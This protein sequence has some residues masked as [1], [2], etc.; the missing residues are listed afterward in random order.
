MRGITHR[1]PITLLNASADVR[2]GVRQQATKT[3]CPP[4]E[5]YSIDAP[6]LNTESRL[7]SRQSSA[8]TKA[9]H[10]ESSSS[11]E[12]VVPDVDRTARAR[13]HLKHWPNAARSP[14]KGIVS[15]VRWKKYV[16]LRFRNEVTTPAETIHA[17]D[18]AYE[19][20]RQTMNPKLI[21]SLCRIL[22]TSITLALNF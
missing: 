5:A 3:L 7:H 10:P 4:S 12:V 16:A 1:F 6:S 11:L 20:G 22:L 17:L 13:I 14:E 21:S 15:R 8:G 2:Q 19:S 18:E 9:V